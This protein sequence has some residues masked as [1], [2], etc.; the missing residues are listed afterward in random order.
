MSGKPC[1]NCGHVRSAHQPGPR[2]H[3]P[4]C[5]NEYPELLP[6]L[7]QAVSYQAKSDWSLLGLIAANL[8]TIGLTFRYHFDVRELMLIYWLQSV[9]IGI[10]FLVRMAFR[11]RNPAPVW[12]MTDAGDRAFQVGFF[13]VH[14]GF[15]H[16]GYLVFL[17]PAAFPG[18]ATPLGLCALV[19]AF[20]HAFSLWH[21]IRSDRVNNAP[22]STLFWLPY[23]RILPMHLSIIGAMQNDARGALLLFLAVKTLADVVMHVV[24]HRILRRGAPA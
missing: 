21:N 19:F 23:A 22:F 11:V 24:E 2:W 15:F 14:Y 8:V 7:K 20:C 10:S 1:P 12:D 3:C 4:N 9:A 13:L 6:P 17:T 16:L 5:H 18:W